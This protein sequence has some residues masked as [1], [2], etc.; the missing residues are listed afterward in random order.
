MIAEVARVDARRGRAGALR[1][2]VG[3]PGGAAEARMRRGAASRR[4]R[5]L[6]RRGDHLLKS[7]LCAVDKQVG[8]GTAGLTYALGWTPL[9]HIVG[10][11]LK[12]RLQTGLPMRLNASNEHLKI[13]STNPDRATVYDYMDELITDPS[14][15]VL[16]KKIACWESGDGRGENGPRQFNAPQEGGRPGL[17]EFR[18]AQWLWADAGGAA[19]P[20]P[21][22]PDPA[23][24]AC[25]KYL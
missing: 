2:G 24:Y 4:V 12:L 17:A 5:L 19:V 13:Q 16:M 22:P 8:I 1:G 21:E 18:A 7:R 11:T 10:G 9:E 25:G 3:P 15:N 23:V 6:R 14:D 20:R